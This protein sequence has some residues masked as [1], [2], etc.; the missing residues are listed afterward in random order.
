M[1]YPQESKGF[2]V[3]TKLKKESN[4][5]NY[6]LMSTFVK[7]TRKKNQFINISNNNYFLNIAILLS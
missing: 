7:K 5:I 3:T 1:Q 2:L 4:K 6:F